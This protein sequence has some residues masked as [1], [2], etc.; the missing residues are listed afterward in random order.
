MGKGNEIVRL[1]DAH[2]DDRELANILFERSR[3]DWD[4]ARTVGVWGPM[5]YTRN[6]KVFSP[7]IERYLSPWNLRG[8]RGLDSWMEQAEANGDLAIFRGLYQ[9]WLHDTVGW[10]GA[11]EHAQG[12]I[13]DAWRDGPN[14]AAR[15]DAVQKFDFGWTPSDDFAAKMYAL[16]PVVTRD[17]VLRHLRRLFWIDEKYE[18]TAA[19]AGAAGDEAFYFELY[20]LT[21]T[22]DDWREDVRSVARAVED[23][24]ELCAELTRR[25][26]VGEENVVDGNTLLELLKL[27]GTDV[28][29]YLERK[30]SIAGGGSWPAFAA[31]AFEQGFLKLWSIIVRENF[32]HESFAQEVKRVIAL[33][34]PSWQRASL[35]ARIAGAKTGWEEWRSFTVLQEDAAIALYDEFPELCKSSFAVHLRLTS[36]QPYIK[37]ADRAAR[38]GDDAMVDLLAARAAAITAGWHWVKQNLENLRWYVD[39]YAALSDDEFA[40]RGF[41]VLGRMQRPEHMGRKRI[42][43]ENPVY[44]MFFASPSAYRSQ[45]HNVRDLLE[46]PCEDARRVGLQ[47][48]GIC[49]ADAVDV[50]VR[51]AD[52]LAAYLLAECRRSTRIA[53]FNA[54]AVAATHS[55]PVA[56]AVLFRAREALDL[57]RRAY[58]RD[59]LIAL[60]GNILHRWPELRTPTEHPV[61]YGQGAAW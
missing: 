57:R 50:A 1:I 15:R 14:R 11:V 31:Y 61:E 60:I 12:S 22:Q 44:R 21:F 19:A 56:D 53:A 18:K 20:R 41:N 23:P 13:E 47:L 16:D 43:S 51:N 9:A 55:R 3:T 46:A 38:S 4:F 26:L 27:R 36:Q 58:P 34:E 30:I 33:D 35:L 28:L 29:P 6:S 54:L 52:H 2:S 17:W 45:L 37:L 5:L 39:H 42:A 8:A 48:L 49:G 25:H 24:N 32:N 7:L 10:N 59:R 40:A